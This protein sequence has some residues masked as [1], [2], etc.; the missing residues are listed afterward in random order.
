MLTGSCVKY[1]GLENGGSHTTSKSGWKCLTAWLKVDW[2]TDAKYLDGENI[3]SLNFMYIPPDQ[4]VPRYIKSGLDIKT[5]ARFRCGNEERSLE[6]WRSPKDSLCRICGTEQETLE[7]LMSTCCPTELTEREIRSE[8]G[9]GLRWMKYVYE[10]RW[11]DELNY[12]N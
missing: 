3:K 1:G 7:H 4:G 9:A 12:T 2:C 6:T 11:A 8:T 5:I 10:S